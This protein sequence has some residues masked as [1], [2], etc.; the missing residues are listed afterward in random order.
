MIESFVTSGFEIGLSVGF[1]GTPA[2]LINEML[3]KASLCVVITLIYI[4]NVL[5]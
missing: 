1:K 2:N 4:L 3:L 5:P